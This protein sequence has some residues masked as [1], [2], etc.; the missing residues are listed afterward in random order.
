MKTRC[1]GVTWHGGQC[2]FS[3]MVGAD[4]CGMHIR[5]LGLPYPSS[6]SGAQHDK[7]RREAMRAHPS[8]KPS[9]RSR[10]TVRYTNL[11]GEYGW[12]PRRARLV[13][14]ADL[15]TGAVYLDEEDFPVVITKFEG[16]VD[17]HR[18][19]LCRYIWQ[20]PTEVSWPE[21]MPRDA[22]VWLAEKMEPYT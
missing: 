7:A 10:R 5:K 1:A 3:A 12:S 8:W 18:F 9:Q 13:R 4:H 21:D 17:G 2:P 14:V 15:K 19:W 20:E 6:L 16:T 11:L 22:T